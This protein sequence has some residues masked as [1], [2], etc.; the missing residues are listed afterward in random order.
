MN[1]LISVHRPRQRSPAQVLGMTLAEVVVAGGVAAGAGD[2]L[3]GGRGA[4]RGAVRGIAVFFAGD[5]TAGAPA[6]AAGTSFNCG[7]AVVS[8][9]ASA[10]SR[11]NVLSDLP[12]I[13][14]PLSL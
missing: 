13:I 8:R 14:T 9:P 12:N 11:F 4:V 1:C 2:V 5:S 7:C 3:A 6:V 10:R